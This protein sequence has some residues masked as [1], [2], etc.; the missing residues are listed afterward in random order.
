MRDLTPS[1]I[2]Q[3]LGSNWVMIIYQDNEDPVFVEY[4]SIDQ[5]INEYLFERRVGT[6]YFPDQETNDRVTQRFEELAKLSRVK[7]R[8]Q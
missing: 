1:Q 7:L 4:Q 2:L 8:R 6:V 3:K 5:L